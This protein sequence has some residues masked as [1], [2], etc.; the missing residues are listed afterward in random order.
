MS[1]HLLRGYTFGILLFLQIQRFSL[2]VENFQSSKVP[3]GYKWA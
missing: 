3:S 2:E 1:A